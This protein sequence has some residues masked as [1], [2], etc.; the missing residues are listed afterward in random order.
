M[1][2]RF[3]AE[4]TDRLARSDELLSE[5]PDGTM[6]RRVCGAA[7]RARCGRGHRRIRSR[8][9]RR[10]R[11]RRLCLLPPSRRADGGAGRRHRRSRTA[12]A[13]STRRSS[14]PPPTGPSSSIRCWASCRRSDH[15]VRLVVHPILDVRRD[16][17]GGAMEIRAAGGRAAPRLAAREL[18]A[19]ARA[20]HPRRGRQSKRLPRSLTA[21]LD[22]VRLA[23]DDWRAMRARL[24]AAI[25]RF[26]P[27]PSAASRIGR[28]RRRSPSCNGSTRATSSSSAC[29]NIP[30][31]GRSTSRWKQPA[32]ASG[33]GLLRDPTVTVLRR[34]AEAGDMTPEIRA[35]LTASDPLIVTKANVKTR[36]HRR[37]YMD[38]VGVKTLRGRQGQRRASDR[39]PLHLDRLHAI[40]ANAFRSSA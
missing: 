25:T 2:N 7:V 32:V 21:L 36:V 17:S 29:A 3:E 16:A 24:H 39:R 20:A 12:P 5:E 6:I 27:R 18:R 31:P 8:R 11:P 28:W 23:T 9:A 10:D 38:Y 26:R 4:K 13:G 30:T 22:E 37:D 19:R 33:L 34:G 35:F 15:P 14:F 40:R 1:T